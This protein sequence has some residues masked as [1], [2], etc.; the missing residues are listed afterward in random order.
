MEFANKLLK[1]TL[2]KRYKRFLADVQLE[3]GQVVVAH[4]PNTGAM[5]G[6]A[7]PGF[8]VWL[9]K[10]DNPKRKLAYTWELAVNQQGHWIGINTN[11]ANK[12]VAE[13]LTKNRLP[14]LTGYSQIRSEVKYGDENSRI[15]FLLHGSNDEEQRPD[16]YVEVKSATLLQDNKGFFPDAKTLRGQKHLRELATMAKLGKRSVLLYCVQ[17]TGI[18]N[19][20]V[21]AHIDPIYAQELE[22]AILDGLQVLC[23]SAIICKENIYIN[24]R[25]PFLM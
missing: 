7:E 14:E 3:N 19:V 20:R 21:A 12:L 9:S 22:Q 17:H 13:A 5:T 18:T 10:S 15:D 8:E 23:Y 11:N 16:C 4:C 6:C 1:G 24:Q 2:L 25:I